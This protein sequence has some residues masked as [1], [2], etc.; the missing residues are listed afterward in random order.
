[1]I[2]NKHSAAVMTKLGRVVGNTMTN[3]RAANLKLIGRATYLGKTHIDDVIRRGNLRDATEIT[4]LEANA[5]LF[6]II[7]SLEEHGRL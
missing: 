2:M 5:L 3:V 7:A 6:D 4:Y 1:M